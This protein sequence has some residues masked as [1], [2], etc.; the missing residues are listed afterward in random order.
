MAQRTGFLG[1]VMRKIRQIKSI[2][3][4]KS[5]KTLVTTTEVS[6]SEL[7]NSDKTPITELLLSSFGSDGGKLHEPFLE[8]VNYD[9][10]VIP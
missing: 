4:K 8:E 2:T 9:E 6:V 7:I 10:V 3:T 5:K 1:H